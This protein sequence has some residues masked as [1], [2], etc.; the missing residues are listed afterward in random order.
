MLRRLACVPAVAV[1]CWLLVDAGRWLGSD[2]AAAAVTAAALLAFGGGQLMMFRDL[3][4][5]LQKVV[6]NGGER[7]GSAWAVPLAVEADVT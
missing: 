7:D 3:R 1:L 4:H 6:W 2:L 5:R